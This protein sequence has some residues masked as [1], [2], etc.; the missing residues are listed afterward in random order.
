MIHMMPLMKPEP[1]ALVLALGQHLQL[2]VF[3]GGKGQ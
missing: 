2:S 3:P 1:S